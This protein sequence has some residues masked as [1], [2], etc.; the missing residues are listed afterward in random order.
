MN[1]HA[2]QVTENERQLFDQ[3]SK[4]IHSVTATEEQS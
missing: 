3:L 1:L 2:C 4:G